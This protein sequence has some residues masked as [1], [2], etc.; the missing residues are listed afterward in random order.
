M[1]SNIRRSDEYNWPLVIHTRIVPYY[2]FICGYFFA[3]K[4][5]EEKL[6][7]Q[8][9]SLKSSQQK[10]FGSIYHRRWKTNIMDNLHLD[11]NYKA[12]SSSS[13]SYFSWHIKMYPLSGT[14]LFLFD[15]WLSTVSVLLFCKL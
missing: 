9:F 11:K 15:R 14:F 7:I 13:F 3:F 12:T 5:W 4:F 2:F 10:L 8:I 6:E 1:S